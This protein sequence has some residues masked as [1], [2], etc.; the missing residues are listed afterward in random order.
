MLLVP[1]LASFQMP[2]GIALNLLGHRLNPGVAGEHMEKFALAI[3]DAD[4]RADPANRGLEQI[5]NLDARLFQVG[6]EGRN[7]L[8]AAGHAGGIEGEVEFIAASTPRLSDFRPAGQLRSTSS[9]ATNRSH[10]LAMRE[11]STWI[12]SDKSAPDEHLRNSDGE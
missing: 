10:T 3:A 6:I 7:F 11:V 1:P 2:P 4:Q 5:D 12:S 8:G 9:P